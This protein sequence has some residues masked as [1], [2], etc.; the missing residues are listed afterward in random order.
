MGG[1]GFTEIAVIL[2]VAFLLFGAK[3]LPELGR[4]AGKALKDFKDA[5]SGIEEAAAAPEEKPAKA[6]KKKA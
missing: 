2:A 1:L 6:K 5:V 4:S 3:R